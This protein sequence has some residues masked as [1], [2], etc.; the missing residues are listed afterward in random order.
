MNNEATEQ[1]KQKL[2]ERKKNLEKELSG[3]AVKDPDVQGD[4]DTKY[5]RTQEGGLEEAAGEVEEYSTKLHIEF[6]LE[7][8][9][10]EVNAALGR[11]VKGTWGICE[12]CGKE[13]A[14][15]RLLAMPE[16]RYCTEC[17]SKQ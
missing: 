13:I 16:S 14:E 8:Q 10:K 12:K 7:N 4:W 15:E 9:L 5:P 11:I 3:F 6:S 17:A 2:E 1:V